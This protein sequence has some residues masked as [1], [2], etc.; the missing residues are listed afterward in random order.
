MGNVMGKKEEKDALS[1]F[2]IMYSDRVFIRSFIT[3]SCDSGSTPIDVLG[4][5]FYD[6]LQLLWLISPLIE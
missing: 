1:R 5:G 6:D 2:A 3:D 4:H